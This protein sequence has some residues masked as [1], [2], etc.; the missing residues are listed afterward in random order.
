MSH[1]DLRTP[2]DLL[3]ACPALLKYVPTNSIV[4]YLGQLPPEGGIRVRDVL[5]F[6][7][8]VTTDQAANF[9]T[10]YAPRPDRYDTA[11]VLAICEQRHDTHARYLL[12]T[13]RDTL[14]SNAIPVLRR[15]YARD[16]TN[17]GQWLDADTGEHGATYPYTDSLHTARLVH[18]GTPI[19][20]SHAQIAATF[21]HLPPAPPVALG[22][23][24]GLVID[25][26]EDIAAILIGGPHVDPTLATRAG[27]VIT[28]HPALRDAM[29]ALALDHP[30][31]AARLWTHISRRLR[32]HQRTQALTIAAACQYLLGDTAHADLA[33]Q[34]AFAEAHATHTATPDLAVMLHAKLAE[35][36]APAEI[37]A[38]ITAAFTATPPPTDS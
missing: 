16:V 7:I 8:T 19:H 29:I 13:V 11:I 17:C 5:R 35:G 27:I 14:Q 25:T 37:R 21:D 26:F 3:A 4:I 32:G 30:Q 1:T 9:L 22:D 38:A 15:L 34:A 24:G 10:V 31:S 33:L 12:D 23:H 36:T 28:A 6:D 20:P 2:A 18:D